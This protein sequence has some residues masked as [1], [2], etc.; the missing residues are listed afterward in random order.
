MAEWDL[1]LGLPDP[2]ILITTLCW[3]HPLRCVGS[4]LRMSTRVTV[5][6]I[7]SWYPILSKLAST[8]PSGT[9]DASCV[10]PH[11]SKLISGGEIFLRVRLS[12]ITI[13]L[14]TS[15]LIITCWK[16]LLGLPWEH[17]REVTGKRF[18]RRHYWAV[19]GFNMSPY[20]FWKEWCQWAWPRPH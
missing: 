9:T 8:R 5:P 18:L 12:L 2:D 17:G 16:D 11:S 6:E 4:T 20:S 7:P 3:N 1:N 13:P 14:T 10:S 19:T 15:H